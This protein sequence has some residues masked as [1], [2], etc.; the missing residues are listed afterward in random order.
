MKKIVSLILIFVLLTTQIN[1]TYMVDILENDMEIEKVTKIN[2]INKYN[3]F[4]FNNPFGGLSSE[5]TN[6][7]RSDSWKYSVSNTFDV[8]YEIDKIMSSESGREVI[9]AVLDSGIK[10]NHPDLNV[11]NDPTILIGSDVASHDNDPSD[12]NSHGTH[13]AGIIG[14]KN[15]DSADRV[16]G[17]A[18]GVNLLAVKV[19]DNSNYGT[20]FNFLDGLRYAIDQGADVINMSFYAPW[21]YKPFQELL[22]EAEE[23]NIIVVAS[24]GNDSNHWESGQMFDRKS[25]GQ[26]YSESIVYPAAY[27]TVLSVGGVGYNNGI[28][29]IDDSSNISGIRNDV[30]R[31]LDVVAPG[32]SIYSSNM[33]NFETPTIKS[34]TSMAA[35][36]VA[37]LAALIIAKYPD[38]TAAEVRDVIRKTAYDPG[39]V[40][41][42]GYN[43]QDT[44]G[45]GLVNVNAALNFSPLDA[46]SIE[47]VD[48]F[49]FDPMK[50]N[51]LI[52]VDRSVSELRFTCE[53]MEG[54]KF[55]YNGQEEI[56]TC[57][58]VIPLEGD[59]SVIE[60]SVEYKGALRKYKFFV[61][62]KQP[63]SDARIQRIVVET[64]FL[65]PLIK[66]KNMNYYVDLSGNVSSLAFR[67]DTFAPTDKIAM[68]MSDSETDFI[69][70]ENYVFNVDLLDK[71]TLLGFKVKTQEGKETS[72]LMAIRKNVEAVKTSTFDP[73]EP[74][75][76]TSRV[77]ISLDTD[78]IVLDYGVD[79]DPNFTSY[80]FQATVSGASKN[81]VFWSLDD[82][83][84]VSVDSNGLVSVREDTPEGLG[85]FS[86][87]LK[88]QSVVGGMVAEAD[89][90]FVERT[91]LGSVEFFEPYISGYTDGTFRPRN[92][93]TRAEV[94]K[95]FSK[96]MRLDQASL[97]PQAFS[98]VS[99]DHWAYDYIQNLY[100]ANIF[101]G[102]GD[103]TFK[104]NEPITR[105]EIAQVFTNYWNYFDIEVNASHVIN[106][107]DVDSNYWA[108]DP[109]HRLYNA[110]V[111][112]GFLNNAYR[113]L[114]DTLREELVFM[115]NNLI[116]REPIDVEE[117]SFTDLSLDYYFLGD[118]EAASQFYVDKNNL[119]SDE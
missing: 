71:T 37:G 98:D 67:L 64:P 68:V 88:A 40:I 27:E 97:L 118:I 3:S 44:I 73:L 75:L 53:A 17:I 89:I 76:V 84:Y 109:I 83:T 2:A 119:D 59:I 23:K 57:D 52:D 14:A 16:V 51:Y 112:P 74:I 107:P 108:A 11:I 12:I 4:L 110:R 29:G 56:G 22:N 25:L 61:K 114:D 91:P 36:F 7:N 35:P 92:T 39:I 80:L 66:S 82:D 15:N 18:P 20:V 102:Y 26:Q 93:I 78:A 81:D 104:P 58:M 85:D 47:N 21:N 48:D 50:Y 8:W 43:R 62:Y 103:E 65:N 72:Y 99:K 87:K 86:V 30:F 95:I 100:L 1:S 6:I 9:V 111:F 55:Y 32:V 79:A 96:I 69:Y 10:M 117:P 13:V 77:N 101:S 54:T 45:H 31:Q 90:L 5:P 113:P 115:V 46:L 49:V 42:E 116:G 24:S 38:L 70:D 28:L 33:R 19:F 105:A 41:P 106:I 34:G 60:F 63:L 94:A